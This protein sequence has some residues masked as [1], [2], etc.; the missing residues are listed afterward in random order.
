MRRPA[1][2]RLRPRGCGR[3]P[4]R[5]RVPCGRPAPAAGALVDADRRHDLRVV[6]AREDLVRL[7]RSPRSAASPPRPPS[8]A[9]RRSPMTRWRVMP[10]RKVPFAAGV[11]TTPSLARKM[12]EVA[13]SAT[14]PSMS[15][16]SAL[17]KP[18]AR[19]SRMRP[20]VVRVEA[21]GLGVGRHRF[22]GRA[23]EARFHD[24]EPGR[25]RHRRLEQAERKPRRVRVEQDRRGAVGL[26]PV[27]RLHIERRAGRELLR[28]VA[29][30][31]DDRLRG[32][33]GF[34]PHALGG[35]VGAG[36]VTVHVGHD[37]LE[38]ARAVEDRGAEPGGMRARADEAG[39]ALVPRAVEPGPGLRMPSHAILPRP[40][41]V[42]AVAPTNASARAASMA[43]VPTDR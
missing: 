12:F 16:T 40:I 24:R 15:Q 6:A 8:P 17:S 35:A 38:H 33:G 2:R 5:V 4:N 28:P 41:S 20:G 32:H 11:R 39:I 31:A 23:A 22:E 13:V 37:A 25:R 19:A 43:G 42:S 30:Q 10:L 36:G 14:L 27:H 3:N 29:G 26:G 21:A 18:L 1:L 9:P 34:E 7:R